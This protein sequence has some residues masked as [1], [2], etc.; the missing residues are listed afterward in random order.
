MKKAVSTRCDCL[1]FVGLGV[2]MLLGCG[3]SVATES[4]PMQQ[5]SEQRATAPALSTFGIADDF[6]GKLTEEQEKTVPKPLRGAYYVETLQRAT[7]AELE[8]KL[9]SRELVAEETREGNRVVA[10]KDYRHVEFSAELSGQ[11]IVIERYLV[12]PE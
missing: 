2:C 4:S 11:M 6:S 10:I 12:I 9:K 8:S 5:S 3:C 7:K 1:W